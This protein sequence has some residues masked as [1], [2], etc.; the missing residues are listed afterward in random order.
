MDIEEAN[1]EMWERAARDL[2]P[3]A[4]G[5]GGFLAQLLGQI[6]IVAAPEVTETAATDGVKI[7]SNPAWFRN[8]TQAQRVRVAAHEI[9]HVLLDH[10]SR[11]AGAS[12]QKKANIACDCAVH[13]LV[14]NLGEPVSGEVQPR[15]L[16]LPD[17]K[18]AEWYMSHMSQPEPRK[19]KPEP[20]GGGK[21][22]P[23]GDDRPAPTG[24]TP[25][26]LA[27]DVIP[28]AAT[29]VEQTQM[30]VKVAQAA[31]WSAT[32][33][34]LP[35]NLQRIIDAALCPPRIDWRRPLRQWMQD[36]T[37]GPV[38]WRTPNR[39]YAGA[40]LYVRGRSTAHTLRE[41]AIYQDTSGS[42]N[43]QMELC[44]SEISHICCAIPNVRV[45]VVPWDVRTYP[46]REY[47]ARD[48]PIRA[49]AMTGG[50]G[51][52]IACVFPDLADRRSGLA[53]AIIVTDGYFGPFPAGRP[54]V[55]VLVALTRATAPTLPAWCRS[56][57]VH[58]P[59]QR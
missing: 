55:P 1:R 48:M 17:G 14:K 36:L 43:A 12:D 38:T 18:S 15:R 46:G 25:G 3:L 28:R 58:G 56:V 4:G 47:T 10:C 51:T 13:D 24:Q 11:L 22:Q 50:G 41:L 37:R 6:E 45:T 31:E 40:G 7:Y 8:L 59:S 23:G 34:K 53:G 54:R 57:Q 29:P 26:S 39:R 16:N 32:R 33:G 35:G 20:G 52:S 2:Y 21:P 9:G 30:A 27:G 44:L 49:A 5:A 42:M 19:P